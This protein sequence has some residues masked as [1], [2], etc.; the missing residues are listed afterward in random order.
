MVDV[1]HYARVKISPHL[2]YVV[3][4]CATALNPTCRPSTRAGHGYNTSSVEGAAG[5]RKGIFPPFD[6]Q[7]ASNLLSKP[8]DADKWAHI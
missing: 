7:V 6:S 8:V 3:L 1:S 2:S 5:P 4:R